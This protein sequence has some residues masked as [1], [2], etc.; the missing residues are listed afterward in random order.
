MSNTSDKGTTFGDGAARVGMQLRSSPKRP[1]SFSS[2]ASTTSN[3]Y[4]GVME[5][6]MEVQRIQPNIF[7]TFS[8]LVVDLVF[9]GVNIS[10]LRKVVEKCSTLFEH[11]LYGYFIEKRMA[12]PVVEYYARN[13]WAKLG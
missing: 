2:V 7:P 1:I 3:P 5:L 11:T 12:F 8:Y 13:N 6:R 9:D 4:A 10:I